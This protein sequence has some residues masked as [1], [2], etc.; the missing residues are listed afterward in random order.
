LLLEADPSV[1]HV[2]A[3]TKYGCTAL[4]MVSEHTNNPDVVRLLL[5]ADPSVEH[6]RAAT[7]DG[8][9]ALDYAE[10][11][12]I[13]ALLRAA[14]PEACAALILEGTYVFEG[15][16]LDQAMPVLEASE[17]NFIPVVAAAKGDGPPELRGALFQIDALRAFNRALA[18]T[19]AEEHS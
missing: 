12:E 18:A 19:A 10:N 11:D 5:E 16:T 14:D 9:K 1:E 3:A 17:S 13:E 4:I 7:K 8:Y 6:V 15:Q 2:R